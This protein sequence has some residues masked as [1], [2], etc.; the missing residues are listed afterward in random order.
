MVLFGEFD[1]RR[2][3]HARAMGVKS[4]KPKKV[5]W[6]MDTGCGRDLIGL[7]F[8]ME[9]SPSS[10]LSIGKRC[11]E[12]GY[13]FCVWMIGE[14]TIMFDDWKSVTR[15]RVTDHIPTWYPTH[16]ICS[17]SLGIP[18]ESCGGSF[19]NWA[20]S[21]APAEEPGEEEAGD[22]DER[23]KGGGGDD[24]EAGRGVKTKK[25]TLKHE[26]GTLQHMVTNS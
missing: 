1:S 9:E 4:G 13:G 10:V 19:E 23:D 26:A 6:L 14:E 22:A 2:T 16:G 18:Q 25:E 24:V 21:A 5:K 11:A 12:Y 15:L 8:A 17:R 20:S 7:P 3:Q